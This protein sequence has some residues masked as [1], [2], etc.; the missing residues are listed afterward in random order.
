MTPLPSLETDSRPIQRP[1]GRGPICARVPQ[2]AASERRGGTPTGGRL[3]L[4]QLLD[5]VWEGLS[6][7]GEAACPVCRG[8]IV[9]RVRAA[10]R[11]EDCGT[12]LT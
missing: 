12:T 11:C 1:R 7:G 3:T 4:G 5:G 9:A 6:A 10:A 2:E 8:R